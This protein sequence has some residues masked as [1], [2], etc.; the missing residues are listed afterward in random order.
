MA[1]RAVVLLGD[2][3]ALAE[4]IALAAPAAAVVALEPVRAS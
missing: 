4:D 2:A 1:T 3:V